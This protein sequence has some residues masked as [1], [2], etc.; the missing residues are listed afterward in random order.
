MHPECDGGHHKCKV[1][2]AMVHALC[3]TTANAVGED[4]DHATFV[5]GPS[6]TCIANR[7]MP[8]EVNCAA[9]ALCAQL[10]SQERSI[11]K[12]GCDH[13]FHMVCL[14]FKCAVCEGEACG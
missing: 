6:A 10:A 2:G 1:C 8:V 5:C 11:Y 14:S 9:G 12:K 4:W 13:K 3:F 7:P